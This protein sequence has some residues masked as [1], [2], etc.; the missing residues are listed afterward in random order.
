M[1]PKRLIVALVCSVNLLFVSAFAQTF[2]VKKRKKNIPGQLAIVYDE[3]LSALRTQPDIKAPLIARLHREREVGIIGA[4]RGLKGGPQFYPVAISRNQR[5]WVIAEALARPQK[6]Q[7]AERL[8][9]LIDDTKDPF[10]RA[11][12]A[13]LYA[14]EFR[15]STAAAAALLKLGEAAEKASLKLSR[16]AKKRTG[17]PDEEI[18]EHLSSRDYLLNFVGLDR[19]NKIGVTFDYDEARQQLIYDGSAYRELLRNYPRSVEAKEAK[20]KL[21]ALRKF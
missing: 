1:P 6:K 12:L 17:E 4:P 2:T 14:D 3:R 9:S 8:M 11:R 5:G 18:E 20:V 10:T 15:G 7:D 13:R 16:D 19:Y 21:Q